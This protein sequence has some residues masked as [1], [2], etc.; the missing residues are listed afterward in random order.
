M[1]MLICLM[2]LVAVNTGAL[3]FADPVDEAV[4]SFERLETYRVTLRSENETIKYF[5]KKPGFIRMEFERPHRGVVLIYDPLKK[6][7][8]L[9]P[10]RF[11]KS[12]EMRLSPQDSLIRSEKGHTV[13]KS[14]IGSLLENVGKLKN[15][16][17]V[18]NKGPGQL[19]NR[20]AF[21]VEVRGAGGFTTP[22]G[23]NWYRLWL[24]RKLMLPLKVEA[25]SASGTLQE[26]V[27]MDDLEVDPVLSDDLFTG[28]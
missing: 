15:N 11:W 23:V 3:A 9:R 14:D 1:K 25:Y 21:V 20:G 22:D 24:D 28:K 16:G 13:D 19:G 7:V 2:A 17:V 26:E 5:F 18:E 12:F 6:E 8:R 27:L 4:S 10:F